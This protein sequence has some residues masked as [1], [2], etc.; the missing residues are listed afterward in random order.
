MGAC[1]IFN[2][3]DKEYLQSLSNAWMVG[4]QIVSGTFIGLLMGI[5]LDKW[6]GTKPWLT[7][8]FL[9]LGIAAGF[10]N[11]FKEIKRIQG[12]DPRSRKP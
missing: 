4:L 11:V 12:N 7:I 6:L 8:V 1:V 2:I 10:K 3:K 5:F 9:L